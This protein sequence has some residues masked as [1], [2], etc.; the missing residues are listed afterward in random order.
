MKMKACQKLKSAGTTQEL[1]DYAVVCLFQCDRTDE[2]KRCPENTDSL[3]HLS[4]DEASRLSS[5]I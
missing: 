2:P 3:S 1:T 5:Q 4:G